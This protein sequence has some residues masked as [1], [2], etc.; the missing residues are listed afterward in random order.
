MENQKNNFDFND[1][2]AFGIFILALL[3]IIFT[4]CK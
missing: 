1:L 3:T 2:L 4:F